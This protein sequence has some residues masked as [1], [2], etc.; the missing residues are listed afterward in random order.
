MEQQKLT[1]QQR[2]VIRQQ[3]Y[4]AKLEENAR[5]A[6]R[7]RRYNEERNPSKEARYARIKIRVFK[8]ERRCAKP[9]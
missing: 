8:Q 3:L 4:Q 5:L 1:K 2:A 7:T 9:A 6:E